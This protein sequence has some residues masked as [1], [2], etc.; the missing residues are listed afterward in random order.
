MA[1]HPSLI[2]NCDGASGRAGV[3]PDG[4]DTPVGEHGALLSRQQHAN[5][6]EHWHPA[7]S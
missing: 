6:S 5:R 7:G 3:L 2:A 4:Y 1:I